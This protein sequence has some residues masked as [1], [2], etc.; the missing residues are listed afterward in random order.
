MYTYMNIHMWASLD[1]PWS[2]LGLP[3]GIS[4]APLALFGFFGFLLDSP[5]LPL[6]SFWVFLGA[7]WAPFGIFGVSSGGLWD[8]IRVV[9][10]VD[11]GHCGF[12]FGGLLGSF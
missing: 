4:W 9:F 10:G 1:L 12:D 7:C 11:L 2:P 3:L 5:G 8:V 6:G